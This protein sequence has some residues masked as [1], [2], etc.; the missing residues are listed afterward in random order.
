SV[1]MIRQTGF[2]SQL[3]GLYASL[4]KVTLA[5]VL[6]ACGATSV[7]E[8]VQGPAGLV[9]AIIAGSFAYF[10]ALRVLRAVPVENG[11]HDFDIL[12]R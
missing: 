12:D 10:A 11:A 2:G 9:G 5:S 1:M 4:T 8:F 7:L 6:C 3:S